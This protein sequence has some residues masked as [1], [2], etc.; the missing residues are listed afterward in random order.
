ME[1]SSK[2]YK[3][4]WENHASENK[5]I[6]NYNKGIKIK[7]SDQNF[8]Q[9]LINEIK[10]NYSDPKTPNDIYIKILYELNKDTINLSLIHISEP[11]RPY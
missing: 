4:L 9:F 1:E 11:T 5:L 6:Y 2:W 7:E 10:K 8:K 3:K